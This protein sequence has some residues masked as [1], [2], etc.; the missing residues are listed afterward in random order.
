MNAPPIARF[1]LGL[2]VVT[3]SVLDTVSQDDILK[4]IQRHQAGDWGELPEE[5]QMENELSL[6]TGGRLFSAYHLATN[7]K[8]WVITDAGHRSTTILLPEDY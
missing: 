2:I 4:A 3:P 6:K 8:F 5:D 1:R 7:L